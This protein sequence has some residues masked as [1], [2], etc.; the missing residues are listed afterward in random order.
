MCLTNCVRRLHVLLLVLPHPLC[1]IRSVHTHPTAS[2]HPRLVVAIPHKA[3]W[4]LFTHL[5]C[6]DLTVA[7]LVVVGP[8]VAVSIYFLET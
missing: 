5:I 3:L 2:C 1:A 8:E 7:L 4:I 6:I